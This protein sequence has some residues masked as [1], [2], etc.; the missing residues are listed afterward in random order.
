MI[1][2]QYLKLDDRMQAAVDEMKHLI[3]SNFPVVEFSVHQGEESERIHLDAVLDM[4]ETLEVLDLILG[5]MVE[6]QIEEGL[7][8]VVIPLPTL[9]RNAALLERHAQQRA[10]LATA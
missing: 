7:P 3:A 6:L 9:E 4:D 2:K 5:R 8:L 10:A 1:D